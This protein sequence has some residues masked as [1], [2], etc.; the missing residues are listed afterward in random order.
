MMIMKVTVVTNNHNS[1]SNI[2]LNLPPQRLLH[3]RV[4]EWIDRFGSVR[5]LHSYYDHHDGADGRYD[6]C[7]GFSA[8]RSP[9]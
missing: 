1:D 9:L 4:M 6:C 7:D 2:T 3:F 8:V 5:L